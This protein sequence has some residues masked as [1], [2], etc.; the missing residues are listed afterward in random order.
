M[1]G[2][3]QNE[4]AASEL[5]AD[6][7][8]RRRSARPDVPHPLTPS[9]Q[10]G[11]GGGSSRR[12][13]AIVG[14][15]LASIVLGGTALAA[16]PPDLSGFWNLS[17]ATREPDPALAALVPPETV[18]LA[19]TGAAE[20]PR[21][22]YGGLV[23]TPEAQRVADEWDPLDDFTLSKACSPPSIAY[24]MQGPFPIEIIQTPELIV[25]R[26][27]YFDVVRLVYMDG[28]DHPP[29]EAP[30]SKAGHSIGRWEGDLLVVDTTHLE[31]STLT[32]NGLYHSDRMHVIERFKL[33]DDG[34]T[35]LATQEYEDPA[36]LQNRGVRYISWSKAE[37]YIYPYECDPTFALEYGAKE[38]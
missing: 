30:H 9:P 8:I 19:D 3:I 7:L 16:D 32:N 5:P 15:F 34:Q 12:P 36:T 27:E 20:F 33:A 14:A 31:P 35:L 25:I 10:G 18:V 11:G 23:L 28:R 21:G 24:S 2:T 38:E 29:A 13:A 1:R 17:F 4:H 26:M 6:S 37:D 22:E